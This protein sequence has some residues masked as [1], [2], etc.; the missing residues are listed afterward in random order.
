MDNKTLSNEHLQHFATELGLKCTCSNCRLYNRGTCCCKFDDSII[1]NPNVL[2][3]YCKWWVPMKWILDSFHKKYPH[4]RLYGINWIKDTNELNA[5]K[6]QYK[7]NNNNEQTLTKNEET[8]ESNEKH[9]GVYSKF[10]EF[11]SPYFREYLDE[12]CGIYQ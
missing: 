3:V 8:N 9:Q 4:Y 6:K 12:V 10:M 2:D 1:D 5:L 11:L 7:E